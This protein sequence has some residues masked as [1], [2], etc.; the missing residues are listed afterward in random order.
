MGLFDFLKKK[1][2]EEIAILRMELHRFKPIKDIEAEV[3]K[4]RNEIEALVSTKENELNNL[5]K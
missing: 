2:L 4:R 5:K 1:E 3:T